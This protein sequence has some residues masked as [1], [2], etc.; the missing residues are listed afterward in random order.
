MYRSN[1][2][3][4]QARIDVTVKVIPEQLRKLFLS[5]VQLK[6][7]GKQVNQLLAFLIFLKKKKKM[8]KFNEG[9]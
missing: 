9:G 1:L 3:K 5:I 8:S 4:K 6:L 2:K 7:V